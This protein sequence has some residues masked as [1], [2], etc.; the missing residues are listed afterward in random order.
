MGTKA[1]FDNE[2]H[3]YTRITDINEDTN[4]LVPKP[5]PATGKREAEGMIKNIQLLKRFGIFR[6]HANAKT[7]D[8]RKYNLFYGRTSLLPS[9]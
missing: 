2:K 7:K 6:S 5:L 8:F 4:N 9:S 1:I 3:K